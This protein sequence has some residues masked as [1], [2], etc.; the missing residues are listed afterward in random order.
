MYTSRVSIG[1]KYTT[2]QVALVS[3][4]Y[5]SKGHTNGTICNAS[6]QERRIPL[7]KGERFPPHRSCPGAAVIWQLSAYA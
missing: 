4:V 6:A 3:G 5:R 1:S 7:S 2:G